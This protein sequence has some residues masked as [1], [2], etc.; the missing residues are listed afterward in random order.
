MFTA[1]MQLI[2]LRYDIVLRYKIFL[3]FLFKYVRRFS[4]QSPGFNPRTTDLEFIAKLIFTLPVVRFL[5]DRSSFRSIL[6]LTEA[7]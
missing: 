4:P 6:Y 3:S 1:Y 7:Y 2:E 5:C